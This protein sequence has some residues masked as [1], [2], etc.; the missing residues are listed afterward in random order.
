M[1]ACEGGGGAVIK[2][3]CATPHVGSSTVFIRIKE[4]VLLIPLALSHVK[5]ATHFQIQN[6]GYILYGREWKL[7]SLLVHYA[8][9]A[10][11]TSTE[12]IVTCMAIYGV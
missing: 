6:D 1:N 3:I 2:I 12:C 9:A 10:F 7:C 5:L 8:A 11:L 4:S